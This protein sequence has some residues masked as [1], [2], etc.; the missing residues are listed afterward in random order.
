MCL[1]LTSFDDGS[2]SAQLYYTDMVYNV[3]HH[4][5]WLHPKYSY[6][7]IMETGILP[8]TAL[9]CRIHGYGTSYIIVQSIVQSVDY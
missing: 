7:F 4:P 8:Y 1:F 5:T 3:G 2:Y 9:F 6:T